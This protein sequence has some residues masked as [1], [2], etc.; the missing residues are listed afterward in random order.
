MAEKKIGDRTFKVEPMLATDAVRLQARLLK[1]LGGGIDRLPE[2]MA[3]AGKDAS[4]EAKAKSNAAAVAAFADI[5]A[6]GDPD[7]MTKLVQEIVETAMVKRPSGEYS[8]VDMDGDFTG[9]LDEMFELAVF[10]LR[11]Q[12]GAFFTGRLASGARAR[13]EKG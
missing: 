11:E 8:L 12:F 1:V 6:N 4:P 5:F 9:R 7:L 13:M 2:I 3:G 10:V